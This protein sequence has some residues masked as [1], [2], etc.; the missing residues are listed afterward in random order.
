MQSI[1]NIED[2]LKM[3]EK[4][5]SA[6]DENSKRAIY[7]ELFGVIEKY[8]SNLSEIEKVIDREQ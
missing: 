7:A 6:L 1:T 8:K 3:C 4:V 2:L 5:E